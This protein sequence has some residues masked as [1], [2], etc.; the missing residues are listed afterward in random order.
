MRNYRIYI[1]ITLGFTLF[2]FIIA[3]ITTP[4]FVS[5]NIIALLDNEIS[6]AKVETHQVAT[7]IGEAVITKENKSKA[8]SSVQK[9][10]VNK[11]QENIYLSVIDWSG[12]IVSYPDPTEIGSKSYEQ[13]AGIVTTE[14]LITGE[15]LFNYIKNIENNIELNVGENI[16]Y[17]L[18]IPNSDL[19]VA[20]HIN[21]KN[22]Q[23]QI[24]KHR[25]YY[26]TS[27]LIIGLITLLFLLAVIRFVSSYYEEQLAIKTNKIEDSVLNLSKLNTSLENHQ[28]NLIEIRK[29]QERNIEKIGN[30]T[31]EEIPEKSKQRLLTYVRNELLSIPTEDIAYIY[32]DNT[33]TYVINKNGRRSTTNDSLDHIFTSLDSKLF[34]RANRQIIVSIQAIETIKKFGNSALKIQT[35]PESEIEIVIGKNK[36]ASFKQW[37]DL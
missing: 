28:K 25:L 32:V 8:I 35:N 14:D 21:I 19:I 18:P 31:S 9:A 4:Y 23:S 30:E 36:A 17:T 34:F 11:D 15:N 1:Y 29:A 12:K 6:T 27:F 37:L 22:I 10:L 5:H 2:F 26:N 20:A 16:I 3:F 24:E 13:A 7:I 33:I